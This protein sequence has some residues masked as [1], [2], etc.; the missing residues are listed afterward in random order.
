M[1][2]IRVVD[3]ETQGLEDDHKVCEFAFT[4]LIKAG[5]DWTVSDTF[6]TLCQVDH[7]PPAARAVHHIS[8]AETQGFPRFDPEAMW[9]QAKSDGVDVIAAHYLAFDLRHFG[10]P[11]LPM[12]CTWKAAL[13][14][15]PDAPEHKNGTLR[16]WLEDRGDIAPDPALCVP[17]HRAGP[18]TYV[19]AH[20]L[21]A[22]LN[23]ATAAQMVAWQKEPP[24]L[25]RCTIGDW[26][27]KPWPE[28]DA[29]FLRWMINKPVE[30]DLVWNARRELE[31]RAA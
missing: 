27:G 1:P 18:D 8:A 12:I 16:Y 3:T 23:H 7:M 15:W 31:R 14:V 22:M 29:G 10:E 26:R 20:L 24:Q 11:Q 19:T 17:A 30:P 25:P 6:S 13:R 9:A 28:V 2:R 21:L 4:D 5:D